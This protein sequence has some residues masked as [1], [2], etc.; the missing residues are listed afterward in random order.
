MTVLIFKITRKSKIM[1]K[2]EPGFNIKIKTIRER[3]RDM[4]SAMSIDHLRVMALAVSLIMWNL[5]MLA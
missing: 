1:E 5:R 2:P 4:T 3:L